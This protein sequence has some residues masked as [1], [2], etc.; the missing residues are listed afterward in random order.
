MKLLSRVSQ[1]RRDNGAGTG[2]EE[3]KTAKR[4]QLTL[5]RLEE[6]QLLAV[7]PG[8]NINISQRAL[9]QV[10]GTIAIDPTDPTHLFAA[11]THET[12]IG[13]LG[14]FSTDSGATWNPDI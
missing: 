2:H 8:P 6:R 1:S 11:G 4:R 13:F 10:E 14:A 7:V 9:H 3:R 12:N 5:E